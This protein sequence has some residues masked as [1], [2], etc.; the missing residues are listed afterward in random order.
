MWSTRAHFGFLSP[1][2]AMGK[3]CIAPK[4]NT[5]GFE[6]ETGHD[7]SPQYD[8]SIFHGGSSLDVRSIEP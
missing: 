3:S 1:P 8:L 4:F 7:K 2:G 6:P 5:P